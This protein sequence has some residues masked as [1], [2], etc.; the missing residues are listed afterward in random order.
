M[1]MIAAFFFFL[2][3]WTVLIL[4]IGGDIVGDIVF[5]ISILEK[6]F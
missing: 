4:D 2:N 1:K 3:F 5:V 6:E